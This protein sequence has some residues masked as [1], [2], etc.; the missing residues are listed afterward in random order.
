[1]I[2]FGLRFWHT[3]KKWSSK[4]FFFKKL[5]I[6][7]WKIYIFFFAHCHCICFF[8][9]RSFRYL[10]LTIMSQSS[11][12][13]FHFFQVIYLAWASGSN[14][15]TIQLQSKK[16]RVLLLAIMWITYLKMSKIQV[17]YFYALPEI[18]WCFS[19]TLSWI[20]LF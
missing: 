9:P 7:I 3:L 20:S 10:P 17:A 16:I 4:P 2:T 1:M 14:S 19:E 5:D 6:I 11:C 8:K 15:Q 13:I 18:A 12:T